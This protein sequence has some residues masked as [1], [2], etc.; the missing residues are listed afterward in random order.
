M[1]RRTRIL[2]VGDSVTA[3]YGLADAPSFARLTAERLAE[4]GLAVDVFVD[5]LDGAD[6][7]YLLRRFDRMITA[8]DPD[9]V[10][11]AIGLNDARPPEGRTPNEP[12]N[13]AGNLLEIVDRVMSLGARPVLVVQNPRWSCPPAAFAS[14]D[15]LSTH[16]LMQS[17]S[18]VVRSIAEALALPLIDVHHALLADPEGPAMIP[19]GTHPNA[20][21]HE[22]MADLA[23]EELLTLLGAPQHAA[24]DSGGAKKS[25]FRLGD[26][27]L[28]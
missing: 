10:V 5:A 25:P 19:D 4:R 13:F 21:G 20:H 3:G 11:V 17:Y 27:S 18:A 15:E 9:W 2:F 24:T 8:H 12:A 7:R 16:D 23:T 26:S 6:S 1:A 28:N 14:P 22:L